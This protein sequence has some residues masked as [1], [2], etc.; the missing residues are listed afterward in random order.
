MT[1][2]WNADHPKRGLECQRRITLQHPNLF[3]DPF[4]YGLR[5]IG[6]QGTSAEESTHHQNPGL[7]RFARVLWCSPGSVAESS[8]ICVGD[9]V[10]LRYYILHLTTITGH[11]NC[12][13]LIF[14]YHFL[15]F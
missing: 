15:I 7:V 3:N 11:W 4:G 8:G 12:L 1:S 6:Q 5:V 9:K 14:D 10:S 2:E 13:I